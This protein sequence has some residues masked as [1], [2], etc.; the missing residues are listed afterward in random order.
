MTTRRSRSAADRQQLAQER[1]D[2]RRRFPTRTKPL[3]VIVDL[4]GNYPDTVWIKP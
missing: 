1:A 3:P 4:G 2:Y